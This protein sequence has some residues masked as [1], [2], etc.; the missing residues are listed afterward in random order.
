MLEIDFDTESLNF[1][2]NLFEYVI[3]RDNFLK[4]TKNIMK[5]KSFRSKFGLS[6][7]PKSETTSIEIPINV[8]PK[9]KSILKNRN[10]N[11]HIEFQ[12]MKR[13]DSELDYESQESSIFEFY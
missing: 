7:S 11:F 4:K 10:E 5:R 13:I 6:V 2:I 3:P 8:K 1:E 12:S 9:L